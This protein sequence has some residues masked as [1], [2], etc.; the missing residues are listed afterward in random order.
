MMNVKLWNCGIMKLWKY[1][2]WRVSRLASHAIMTLGV[3]IF[4][5]FHTSAIAYSSEAAPRWSIAAPRERIEWDVAAD[6]R[7]P[8]GDRLEMSGLGASLI[9]SYDVSADRS[10]SLC[11]DVYWPG[12][13]KQPN[14]TK[15]T[16][17]YRFDEAKVPKPAV[18][19][20]ACGER[21]GKISFDGVWCA[22]S[23]S[24]DGSFRIVRRVFPS[25]DKPAAFELIE[26]ENVGA[27]PR[28]VG[29]T[30]GFTD[31]ALGCT[32]RCE[33]R[34]QAFPGAA[35]TLSPG[36][37]STWTLRL[38][39]RRIDEPDEAAD[40]AAELAARRRRVAELTAPCVLD[41]GNA[42]IDTAFHFAKL[43]AGESIFATRGGLMHSPGGGA[44]YAAT[45]CNDQVEYAGPWFAF[46][47][48]ETA[49]EA[50]MNAYRHYM[51]FM[52]PRYEPIP[53]SVI[54]E[55]TG[56]WNGKGDRGDAA[57]WA[58]GAARF[59]LAAGRRDWA[60][61][62]LPGIRWALEYCRRKLTKDGVVASDCDELETRLPAGDANLCTSS[63]YA[64]AL[65]H[66]AILEAELGNAPAAADCEA[67]AAEM[68]RAIERH[69][70]C[71][72]RGFRTYR[73]YDGCEVLRAWIGIP[74]CMGILDRAEGTADALF[75]P[76]LWNGEGM[77]SAEGDKKGVTWD[78]SALYAFR[79]VFAAGLGDKYFDKF[80]AYTCSRLLGEHVPYAV[81][82]WPEGDRR[83]LSA[84]SALYCRIVTEGLFGIDPAGLGKFD[85]KPRLPK[86]VERMTLKNIRAFGRVFSITVDS[87]GTTVTDLHACTSCGACP[88]PVRMAYNYC[89]LAYTMAGYGEAEWRAEI[90][91]FVAKGNGGDRPRKTLDFSA[92]HGVC[93]QISQ[94]HF[95]A[96]KNL[97]IAV[98]PISSLGTKGKT[99]GTTWRV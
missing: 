39:V 55:G 50:S 63:L 21:V 94:S 20:K 12:Y 64:D 40:G 24:A 56:Y 59:A 14:N 70:G 46:T 13:R 29:F 62:L 22:E 74:L 90:E 58:Y 65:R 34:A 88:S 5:Y 36:E 79:G 43:R 81:E 45:W 38:S 80:A 7:L 99:I 37:K 69:F 68:T 47:G 60:E 89:T 49:L 85:A 23:L 32:G 15:G 73:Y 57:M 66:A 75:S 98:R 76:A 77:L 51:P 8:H 71:E 10:L 27:A 83:H 41:T 9:L 53:S 18:D 87:D 86:G 6:A 97:T 95:P 78:R 82:A 84:E 52:G 19:G 2:N 48:D 3:C 11:R 33:V 72:M 92:F 35:T 54:A 28:T 1:G 31:Y 61:E 42:E 93:P 26:V 25:V 96:G 16:F 91:R 17:S 30:D 44:Y 4:A 67:R